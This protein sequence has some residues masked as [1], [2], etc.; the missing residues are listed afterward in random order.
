MRKVSFIAIILSIVVFVGGCAQTILYTNA[1][2]INNLGIISL[3]GDKFEASFRDRDQNRVVTKV[4]DNSSWKIDD[5][6]EQHAKEVLD[7]YTTYNIK[8]IDSSQIDLPAYYQYRNDN[9][10]SN[11]EVIKEIMKSN[12][13]DHLII[14]EAGDYLPDDDIDIVGVGIER[15]KVDN[16]SRLVAVAN[17]HMKKYGLFD[18]EL[19][20]LETE[21]ITI[22]KKLDDSFWLDTNKPIEP[23]NLYRLEGIIKQLLKDR[24]ITVSLKA[25]GFVIVSFEHSKSTSNS[26]E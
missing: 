18:D 17:I 21:N 7:K 15:I 25:L 5:F 6:I 14:I 12:G 16:S 10:I 24:V 20:L 2:Q 22:M 8:T 23:K 19:E 3:L 9:N 13:L 1:K 4:H 11:P 26:Y